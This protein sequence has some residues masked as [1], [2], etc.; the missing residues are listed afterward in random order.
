MSITES[1][2]KTAFLTGILWDAADSTNSEFD[3]SDKEDLVFVTEIRSNAT[4]STSILTD[5]ELRVPYRLM[6]YKGTA[7]TVALYLELR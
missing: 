5:Y 6:S 4:G 1:I 2:N 7:N 3:H